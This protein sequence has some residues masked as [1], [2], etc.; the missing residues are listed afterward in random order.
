MT[1]QFSRTRTAAAG[2]VLAV[3]AGCGALRPAPVAPVAPLVPPT[4]S[5]AEADRKLALVTGERAQAEAAF[6]A[7]EQLCYSKF[8]VNNCLDAAREKRRVKLVGL[9]AVE[10]EAEH[11]KR[12]AAVDERDR[13]IA[14]ADKKFEAEQARM[15]A[16]VRA[17]RTEPAEPAPKTAAPAAGRAAAQEAKLKQRAAQEQ[18]GAAKRAA[19]VAAFE[20]R[21]RES[22]QRQREIEAKK[23][24]K[25]SEGEA[26]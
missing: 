20:K 19:N 18:A 7:S 3:L 11:F 1:K 9:R 5:V 15:A 16:E 2:L 22:E 21:K 8:L 10:I 17:P 25:V 4:Q 13:E 12:K 23:K 6:A 14:E 26:K 24:A